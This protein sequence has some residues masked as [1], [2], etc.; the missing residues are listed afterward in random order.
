M[1]HSIEVRN[2]TFAYPGGPDV[3][4]GITFS[5]APGEKVALTGP[6]GAGKSTLIL[7]LNGI[8]RGKGD[9][10]VAGISLND[11]ELQRIRA[12]VGLV[13]Q[14][15]DDQLFP[16]TVEEDVAF[17]PLHMGCAP[18]E[19]KTR[20]QRALAMVEMTGS[21]GRLSHHPSGGEKKRVAIATVLAMEPEIL[22]LDEPTAGLDPRARR[23]LI[24]TLRDLPQTMLVSTHDLEMPEKFCLVCSFLMGGASMPMARPE[25]YSPTKPSSLRMASRH[26]QRSSSRVHLSVRSGEFIIGCLPA[27]QLPGLA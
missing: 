8:L 24:H 17:G 9:I 6:N 14:Y 23:S 20:V 21:E 10:Q 4:Q 27:G 2:V 3:L 18:A 19:V 15:P 11:R 12:A 1:H 26:S 16:P 13:F 5:I 22:V 25:R 7:Q